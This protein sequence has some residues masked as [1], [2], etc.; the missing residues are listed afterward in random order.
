MD[1]SHLEEVG[2]ER[3]LTRGLTHPMNWLTL[4]VLNEHDHA[5]LE[6]VAA[7]LVRC[8]REAPTFAAASWRVHEP[9][10]GDTARGQGAPAVTDLIG[11][12][13]GV[14]VMGAGSIALLSHARAAR[15]DRN[16]ARI[17]PRR[18]GIQLGIHLKELGD[19]DVPRALTFAREAAREAARLLDTDVATL[20]WRV[21]GEQHEEVGAT[22]LG[23][24]GA[25]G[26]RRPP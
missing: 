12:E 6:G 19:D 15:V 3:R 20:Q 14:M 26:S 4:F 1:Y 23:A 16:W 5:D 22:L 10:R 9:G 18:T 21:D 17:V 13:N 11:L 24:P 7:W 2:I 25:A 8:A